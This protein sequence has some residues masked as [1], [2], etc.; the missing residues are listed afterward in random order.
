MNV[1]MEDEGDY[2]VAV[3]VSFQSQLFHKQLDKIIIDKIL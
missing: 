2:D 3:T 1:S